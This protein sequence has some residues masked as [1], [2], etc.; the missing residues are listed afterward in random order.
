MERFLLS[1][2]PDIFIGF[3]EHAREPAVHPPV[4]VIN[5]QAE[6]V[7]ETLRSSNETVQ[8]LISKAVSEFR[9]EAGKALSEAVSK[10][11][12]NRAKALSEVRSEAAKAL[13]EVR[14][15]AA[16]ALSE[17]LFKSEA[18]GSKALSEVRLDLSKFRAEV[19]HPI[20]LRSLLDMAKVKLGV[21]RQ[22]NPRHAA[23][24]RV[25]NT[26]HLG[27]YKTDV[28][29]IFS[30]D[31]SSVRRTGNVAAHVVSDDDIRDAVVSYLS[32]NRKNGINL[33]RIFHFQFGYDAVIGSHPP[34]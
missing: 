10:S 28:K 18:E 19:M 8:E 31:D 7:V 4:Q 15:E 14:S 17:A 33:R 26:R 27:L 34:L 24:Q 12:A 21:S 3:T 30:S 22:N 9:S 32:S 20:A 2:T 13:S 1:K 16:K 5:A 25:A 29:V 11:E 6:W 23:Y